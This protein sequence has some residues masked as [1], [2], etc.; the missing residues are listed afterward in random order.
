M[1]AVTD[2]Q[3][4]FV[5]AFV[6]NGGNATAAAREAGYSEESARQSGS[7]LLHKPHVIDAIR[8]EQ[9]RLISG[10]LCTKALAVLERVLDD[11]AAPYGA[12]VD[13]AKTILDRGGLTAKNG[14][15]ESDLNDK[16]LNEMS[17]PEL[18][19]FIRRG[20]EGIER[21]RA[22]RGAVAALAH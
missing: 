5:A 8:A 3:A 21:E 14:P 12:R 1:A 22:E 10:K 11:A 4:A 6:S 9:G 18:E 20:R 2:Q 17:V 13:A 16:P 19:E 7:R 15:R